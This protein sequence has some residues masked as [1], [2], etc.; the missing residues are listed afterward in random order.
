MTG[1]EALD[2]ARD[3]LWIMLVVAGPLMLI[4]LLVG[5]GV[6][7]LQALTQIQEQTLSFVPKLLLMSLGTALLLPFMGD[8]LGGLM[9]RLMERIIS[10]G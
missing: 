8:A 9:Q 6:S 2:V 7:L 3:S 10:G 4:A 5:F 1:A